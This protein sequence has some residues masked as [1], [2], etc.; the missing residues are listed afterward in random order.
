MGTYL[1][2][3]IRDQILRAGRLRQGKALMVCPPAAESI[4]KRESN[5]SGVDLDP[6][7]HGIFSNERTRGYADS[8][9]AIKRAQILCIDEGHN[10]LNFKSQRTQN[11]LRNMADHV[12][13]FTATP[14]NKSANDL[15]RIADMLGADN[16]SESTIK[17][18]K[19]MLR[20]KSITRTLTD[21][22]IEDLRRE[23]KRFTV[24]RT[25]KQLNRLID[26]EPEMYTDITG[27][28]CRFPKHLAKIYA[29]NES[30]QDREIATQIRSLADQLHGVSYFRKP[31]SMPGIFLKQGVPEEKYLQGRLV[32]AKRLARYIITSCLR[33]SRA[34]LIE[35]ITGTKNAVE[36]AEIIGFKKGKNSPGMLNQINSI[37][38]K[39]PENKLSIDL[40]DWLSNTRD[41]KSACASD[42]AIYNKILE[43]AKTLSSGRESTKVKRLSKLLTKHKLVLAFDSKPITLAVI[44]KMLRDSGNSEVLAAWGG[45][46]TDRDKIISKFALGSTETDIIGLCSDSLAEAVNLQQASCLVHMDMPSVVRIAEQRVGRVDRMDSPHTQIE[47]WWPEDSE[48]FALT[49]DERFIER[50]DTVEKL[51]GSN[52]PLPDFMKRDNRKAV[53]VKDIISEVEDQENVWDGIDDAFSPVRSLVEGDNFLVP[54]KVYDR[55]RHITEKVLSRVS[56]VKSKSSWALFCMTSG[57]FGSP[58]W[59]LLPSVNA[60]AE[61]ELSRI[62][63]F[64][65]KRLTSEI[66]DVNLDKHSAMILDHFLKQLSLRERE[67]LSKKKQRALSEM[68]VIIDKLL[69]LEECKNSVDHLWDVRKMLTDPTPEKQ[70]DWDEVASMWLDVIRPVWFDALSGARNKPLLLKD[71]RRNLLAKPKWLTEQ[72]ETHFNQ[73]PILP[74]PDERIKACIIGVS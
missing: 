55:Y 2:G 25:K 59:V 22:E 70:P 63:K 44:Q 68:E 31:I 27:K 56:L 69:H 48:E 33:S 28:L 11:L 14:I 46:G 10:F 7:S 18:F 20:V 12:M 39:L 30:R 15:L 26:R 72:I 29:L 37:M 36:F 67:L 51:L 49:S 1:I 4:W 74:P 42:S 65:R 8:L 73:F 19:R 47:I 32:S 24:R 41:H 38:E 50:Y 21:E 62:A 23:I 60:S 54:P 61:T 58:I 6:Y 9:D 17:A 3:A 34:A 64:L 43:L 57:S 52:M 53:N 16:L 71:I 13:L 5:L 66:K 40:P 45:G 35:H